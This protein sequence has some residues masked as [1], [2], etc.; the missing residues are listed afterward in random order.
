M[1]DATAEAET[2]E[3]PEQDV[4]EE[5]KT[6]EPTGETSKE[7]LMEDVADD[8]D[9]VPE[10][11]PDYMDTVP[12]HMVK[13]DGS[14]DTQEAYKSY[15]G[16]VKEVDDADVPVE[17]V[18]DENGQIK[19]DVLVEQRNELRKKMSQSESDED[20]SDEDESEEAS[21]DVPESPDDYD[22]KITDEDGNEIEDVNEEVLGIAKEAGHEAG[23]TQEQLQ[24]FVENYEASIAEAQKVNKQAEYEKIS[25]D[26]E[27]A[28]KI[29]NQ[30]KDWVQGL[31]EQGHLSDAEYQ[32][33]LE[34]GKDA[35][36]INVFRRL[37][38]LTKEETI[39]TDTGSATGES[40]DDL[41]AKESK[42]MNTEG[43]DDPGHPDHQR[44]NRQADRIREKMVEMEES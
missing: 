34:M 22:I 43:Y 18:I 31:H 7:G 3:A 1:P 23:L 28:K 38:Q 21:D 17:D 35:E 4:A 19:E 12:D 15:Q 24:N 8:G 42:I 20:E 10:D 13:E 44:L 37:Q 29:V 40:M 41:K 32:R 2:E 11:T 9:G 25:E 14:L 36:S 33:A 39:P 30:T 27:Q 6:D 5:T 26:P 16:L